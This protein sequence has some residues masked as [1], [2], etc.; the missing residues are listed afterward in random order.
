[1]KRITLLLLII[2][3]TFSCKKE[4]RTTRDTVL[5]TLAKN[6]ILTRLKSPS[7]AVFIDSL[8]RTSKFKDSDSLFNVRISVDAKNAFGTPLRKRY[9]VTYGYELSKGQDT[10]NSKNYKLIFFQ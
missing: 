5:I 9:I 1:M 3:L 7:S 2:L 8:N 10:L 4:K 6:E